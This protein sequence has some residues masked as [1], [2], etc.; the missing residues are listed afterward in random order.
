MIPP[1][2]PGFDL[3]SY[4]HPLEAY[5]HAS[6]R[7]LLVYRVRNTTFGVNNRH[8]PLLQCPPLGLQLQSQIHSYDSA[9]GSKLSG[10]LDPSCPRPRPRPLHLTP[11]PS[12]SQAVAMEAS[13]PLS[14]LLSAARPHFFRCRSQPPKGLYRRVSAKCHHHHSRRY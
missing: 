3:F 14:Q 10:I 5:R 11:K 2:I 6:A 8:T 13:A 7:Y 1:T 9:K 4:T 12:S